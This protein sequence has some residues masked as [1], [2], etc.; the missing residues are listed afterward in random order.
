MASATP[1]RVAVLKLKAKTAAA[2]SEVTFCNTSIK[3]DSNYDTVDSGCLS[4]ANKVMVP[5][6]NNFEISGD[7]TVKNAA[8]DPGQA[9]MRS[10][11]DAASTGTD[12]AV[13]NYIYQPLGPASGNFE[14]K[15]EAYVATLSMDSSKHDVVKGSFKLST[16]GPV[17]LTDI[18]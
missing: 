14:Y 9:I 17:T 7:I 11:H 3:M 13:V 4:A 8:D 2:G 10:A 6:T 5:T 16:A 15:G 12:A 18:P 1:T